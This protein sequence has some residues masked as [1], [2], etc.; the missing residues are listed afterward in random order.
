MKVKEIKAA[1]LK[2][3]WAGRT[4][5][6]ADTAHRL[7]RLIRTHMALNH[8]YNC[9]IN[10]CSD[11]QLHE[12]LSALQK[13]ARTDVGKMMETVFSCGAVAYNGTD[14]QPAQFELPAGKEFTALQ[15]HEEAFLAE[16]LAEKA[17]EHQMRTEAVLNRLVI[18]SRDRLEYL[19]SC[20]R[21]ART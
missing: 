2:K 13:T 20:I 10:R 16:L 1:L 6:R 14:L 18:S 19:R 12:R 17:L 15:S 7:N 5:S 11:K 21:S 8:A 9:A 4:L 3:G